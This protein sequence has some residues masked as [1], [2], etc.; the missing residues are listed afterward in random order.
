MAGGSRVSQASQAVATRARA[1][2]ALSGGAWP[3]T[4]AGVATV[5]R[6]RQRDAWERCPLS[7]WRQMMG[8]NVVVGATMGA[9][10]FRELSWSP[11]VKAFEDVFQSGPRTNGLSRCIS[12]NLGTPLRTLVWRG[13]SFHGVS[14]V[15]IASRPRQGRMAV[16]RHENEDWA[17]GAASRCKQS[18]SCASYTRCLICW[19]TLPRTR[20]SL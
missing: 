19:N 16:S 4:V 3:T 6:R 11:P 13:F 9:T 18:Q 15:R 2:R 12:R 10:F 1:A 8:D 14:L 7:K 5:A 17:S 20:Q